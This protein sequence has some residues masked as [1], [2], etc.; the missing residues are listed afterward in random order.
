MLYR[1]VAQEYGDDLSDDEGLELARTST[2]PRRLGPT[3]ARHR[4]SVASLSRTSLV[5]LVLFLV[6]LVAVYMY[7]VHE[8]KGL[9]VEDTGRGGAVA[10]PFSLFHDAS[11]NPTPEPTPAPLTVGSFTLEKLQA[12][13]AETEKL[14]T[15]LEE[16]YTN[17]NQTT[18]M[19][20]NAWVD[21][22]DFQNYTDS[23]STPNELRLH[24]LVD[25]M[26]RALVTDDQ[27][28]FLMGAIGSSVA[29]GHD[30]CHYDSYE[31][32]MERTFGGIWEA[33]GMEFVFQ[34]AGEGGGCGDS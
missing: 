10:D 30:N 25:T 12:T 29:A 18:N 16:Y 15:M 17:V 24:K 20:L 2:G 32:Q 11:P 31:S 9:T 23:P 1:Q 22:W 26:A 34:N 14:F 4:L 8:G 19:L 21:P 7:G 6:G 3:T 28:Q 5:Q 27:T 33:A 13:R